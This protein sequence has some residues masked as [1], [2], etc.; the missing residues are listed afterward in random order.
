MIFG[1][2]TISFSKDVNDGKRQCFLLNDCLTT[3]SQILHSK[4]NKIQSYDYY[5]MA[6]HVITIYANEVENLSFMYT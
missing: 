2:Y 5:G 6:N 4:I 1:R 3:V